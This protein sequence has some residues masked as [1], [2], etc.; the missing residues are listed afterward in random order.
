MMTTLTAM[1]CLAAFAVA[2]VSHITSHVALFLGSQ[3]IRSYFANDDDFNCLAAF[4]V[5]TVSHTT[6]SSRAFLGSGCTMVI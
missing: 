3:S 5:A 1:Y 2:T 6:L 4:A